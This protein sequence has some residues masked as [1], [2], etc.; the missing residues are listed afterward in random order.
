M[1]ARTNNVIPVILEMLG[2]GDRK[3]REISER[4]GTSQKTVRYS[5]HKLLDAKQIH[6]AAW[7]LLPKT[8]IRVPIYRLGP[9]DGAPRDP[10]EHEIWLARRAEMQVQKEMRD[11]IASA[12]G[13][14]F[15]VVIAQLTARG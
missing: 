7:E 6:I 9:G 15:A 10:D 8:S 3:Q 14:P 4:I 11:W 5:I 2:T 13:N 12:Q 1:M